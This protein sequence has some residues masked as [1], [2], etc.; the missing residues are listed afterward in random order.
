MMVIFSSKNRE[1]AAKRQKFIANSLRYIFGK[2][3]PS[4]SWQ[5]V[6][7]TKPDLMLKIQYTY[8]WRDGYILTALEIVSEHTCCEPGKYQNWKTKLRGHFQFGGH[9][10]LF[11]PFVMKAHP[12]PTFLNLTRKQGLEILDRQ[13]SA[14]PDH[15]QHQREANPRKQF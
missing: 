11:S 9:F 13:S 10:Q 1:F 3:T 4:S 2:I 5:N 14:D 15:R 7:E 12:L 8:L 6:E